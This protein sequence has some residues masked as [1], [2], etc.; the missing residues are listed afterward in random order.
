MF[1]DFDEEL[2]FSSGNDGVEN[3]KDFDEEDDLM[4]FDLCIPFGTELYVALHLTN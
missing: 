4:E 2:I 3:D 1:Y